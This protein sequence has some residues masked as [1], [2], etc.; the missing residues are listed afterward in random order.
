MTR[1]YFFLN[2]EQALVFAAEVNSRRDALRHY[3]A[4]LKR[5]SLSGAEREFLDRQVTAL[6]GRISELLAA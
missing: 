6:K 2:N 5:D 1:R 4:A 3:E